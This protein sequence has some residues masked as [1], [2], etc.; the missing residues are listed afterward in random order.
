MS[1]LRHLTLPGAGY[2]GGGGGASVIGQL[3]AACMAADAPS[4]EQHTSVWRRRRKQLLGRSVLA[5]HADQ[6]CYLPDHHLCV[7]VARA[8]SSR[9][10]AGG[11]VV[12]GKPI[13]SRRR[14]IRAHRVAALAE[15]LAKRAREGRPYH[16]TW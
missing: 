13:N 8:R 2:A 6:P 12:S 15:L 1:A 11:P 3:S 10:D 9:A 4:V 16:P 7:R 14:A 5:F